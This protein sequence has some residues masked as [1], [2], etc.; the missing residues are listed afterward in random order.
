MESPGPPSP[1]DS[2][3]LWV[4]TNYAEPIGA[5]R[6]S[7]RVAYVVIAFC[8]A[9]FL[10]GLKALVVGPVAALLLILGNVGVILGLF[11]AHVAWTI[12][13]IVKSTCINTAL[14]L[15]FLFVLPVFLGL[16]LAIAI[17]GS[18]L[19]GIGY[20]FFTPWLS[21]FEAFRE[22]NETKIIFR[23]VV[24]GTW[25]TIKGSCTVV[26]DFADIC[27]HSYPLY[28][29]ELREK[30]H[31]GQSYS[32]RLIEIPACVVVASMGVVVTIPLYTVIALVKS[33]YML[34]KGWQ[35]LLQDLISREGPFSET[36]CV[37]I[38]GLAILLWPL[39]VLGSFLLAVV[40]SIFIG[41]YGSVIVYQERS[42]KRGV[43]FVVAM[44]AEFDEYTN[45]WLY[46]REGTILPK[47]R[48][49][50]RK[51]SQSEEFSIGSNSFRAVK[52]SH[53]SSS[54]P[55]MLVPSLAP[56]RSIRETIQEVKMVQVW[57]EIMKSCETRGKE[58]VDAN[59]IT[60]FHL[61][62]WLQTKG[63][64]QEMVGIG[65]PSYAFLHNLL[66]S[67]KG[68][69]GGIL[70]SGGIE[71]TH[72]NRPQDRLLDWFFHPVM[73]LME[74]IRVLNLKDDEVKFLEKLVLFAGSSTLPVQATGD[75]AMVG[76]DTI[77]TAQIQAIS[78]RL[79]GMTRSGSKFPTYR[80]RFRQVI[81]VILAY[82]LEQEGTI[83]RG[84]SYKGHSSRSISSIEIVESEV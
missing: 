9:L 19:V 54:A 47:P 27:Y 23:F 20:G 57:G 69:S 66:F 12:Y 39:V 5:V 53:A 65:L 73:V 71:V 21:T 26:R 30:S 15:A 14:R 32:I 55:S 48:Y 43:A 68:G 35:R 1:L 72:F 40:S 38:A 61:R 51:P 58:L 77:R 3:A 16:W 17:S 11:P 37:P 62:E 29:K 64:S 22:D 83:E 36:A 33:P 74:Q 42:F 10:G 41:L 70:L 67:I 63:R 13:S 76:Q 4:R 45:D 46:L 49:R 25:S 56:S 78:R 81:K 75:G 28:L 24:D 7:A 18:V 82:S 31:D 8:S 34:F 50:K 6:Q 80:R 84:R 79:V 60:T 44:V 59:I 52:A 2:L